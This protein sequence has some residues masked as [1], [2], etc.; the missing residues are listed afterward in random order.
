MRI[1]TCASYYGTGSSAITDLLSEYDNF[2]S[3]GDYEFRFIQD[4]GGI[5]DLEYNIVEN[6]H[7]HNSGNA[8]KIYK[9]NVDFLSGNK[10]VKKYEPFFNYKW[11][12]YSYDYIDE[13]TEVKYN[14]YW[15]QDVIN[16]GSLFY[17]YKRVLNKILKKTI[18][19]NNKEKSLNELPNEITLCANPSKEVFLNATRKYIE[20]LFKEAN[21]E[22]KENVMVDQIVPPSNLKRYTRYF[23]NIKVFV[24]DRDPRDIYLLEKYIWKGRVIPTE[25]VE[26]FC[27]WFINTRK[28]RE[29]EVYSQ[30]DVMFVQFENLVYN[31]EQTVKKIENW[32]GLDSES[33]IRKKAKF[34]PKKS[35]ENTRLWRNIKECQND[36]MYIEEKL[37]EY[38][39]SYEEVK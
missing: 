1:V 29:T 33:H 36:I 14:G 10:F 24:V 25:S 9:K 17:T 3:L 23:N 13:L 26:I 7:R 8:L 16:R 2:K 11:K 12:K 37:S 32:L 21:L 20:R 39:F 31:Y 6:H 15:H 5:C 38:I 35:I 30:D 27:D 28:H 22:N 34:D 4:P 18:W 19:R